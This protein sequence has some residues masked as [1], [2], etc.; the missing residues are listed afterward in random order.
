MSGVKK[1]K[2]MSIKIWITWVEIRELQ[3]EKGTN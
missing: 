2:E 1:N 3:D